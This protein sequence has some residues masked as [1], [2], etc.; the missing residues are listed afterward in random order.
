M[1]SDSCTLAVALQPAASVIVRVCA[2]G[3]NLVAV[4]VV[5]PLSQA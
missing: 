5:S 1:S 2:P 4:A 3:A